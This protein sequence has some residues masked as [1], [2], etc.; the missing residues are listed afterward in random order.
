MAEALTS[1]GRGSQI[2]FSRLANAPEE[3]V[4]KLQLYSVHYIT[5]FQHSLN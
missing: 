2:D 3:I 4:Y 5:A 1:F